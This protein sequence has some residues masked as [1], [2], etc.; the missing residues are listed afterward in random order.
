MRPTSIHTTLLTFAALIAGSC[1]CVR[2]KDSGIPTALRTAPLLP[3]SGLMQGVT[4]LVDANGETHG[5]S[6]IRSERESL[7]TISSGDAGELITA[8]RSQVKRQIESL[9]GKIIGHGTSGTE[10]ALR[11]F[12]YDYDWMANTGI[13]RVHSCTH[14]DGQIEIGLFCY[15]HRR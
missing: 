6:A 8:Y 5:S 1:G 10:T 12:S 7:I 13:V 3:T 4:G 9:G 15:E 14:A 11:G 2:M